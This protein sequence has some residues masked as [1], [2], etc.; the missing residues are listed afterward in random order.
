M[1]TQQQGRITSY[2]KK[3]QNM[4]ERAIMNK[5]NWPQK[6]HNSQ[7]RRKRVTNAS[8]LRQI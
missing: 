5:Q 7:D 2:L 3:T 1:E 6:K 4:K 8:I